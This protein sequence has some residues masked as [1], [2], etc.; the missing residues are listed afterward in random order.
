MDG[1]LVTIKVGIERSTCQWVQL[2]SLTFNELRLECLNTKSVKCRGTVQKNWMTFHDILKYIPDHR[3]T[4]VYNTFCT[5]NCL[6]NSAFNKFTN[7]KR[8][9]QFCC[10]QLRQTA[11]THLQLR[12]YDDN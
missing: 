3:F 12:T 11:L 4:A 1:H 2:N 7:D 9:V 6:Y 5:L 8:F 10:H